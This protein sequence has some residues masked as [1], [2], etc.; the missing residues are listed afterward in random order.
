MMRLMRLGES[1]PTKKTVMRNG[2]KITI[3]MQE[4]PRAFA[5]KVG[6]KFTYFKEYMC[7]IQIS[8]SLGRWDYEMNG[9][10]IDISDRGN[11][12]IHFTCIDD[13]ETP[14]GLPRWINQIPSVVGSRNAEEYNLEYFDNGGIPPVIITV[15]GGILAEKSAKEIKSILKGGARTKL[16]GAV[17][18]THAVGG[19]LSST[20]RVDV[21]VERFGNEQHKDSMFE[22]YD[23]KCE[24]R[25]RSSFRLPPLFVGKSNDYSY[26][27]AFASY[28]IGEAQV[29]KPE[30]LEFDEIIN[31]TIMLELDPNLKFV[32]N[33]LKIDNI[34]AQLKAVELAAT[35]KVIGGKGLVTNLNK[36]TNT[37]L[38][39]EENSDLL[40]AESA[41]PNPTT[42]PTQVLKYD[43]NILVLADKWIS[44]HGLDGGKGNKVEAI[45]ITKQVDALGHDAKLLFNKF[46]ANKLL[47]D[48]AVDPEGCTELCSCSNEILGLDHA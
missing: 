25:I 48:I 40:G 5:Q 9:E 39:H 13:T 43:N 29:F 11:E 6:T 3:T 28:A 32:S 38:E 45:E 34:D 4:R 12:I 47:T 16:R 22:N 33:P 23:L 31:K 1:I 17:I 14:Y 10:E 44:T 41:V 30:R 42:T 27:T 20:G 18:E 36:L 24:E 21:K 15:S 19:D 37:H 46:V 2:A 8:A 7:P 26:A 35:N